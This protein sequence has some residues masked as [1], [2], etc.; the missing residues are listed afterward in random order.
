MFR[1]STKKL[2]TT[3]KLTKNFFQI[4]KEQVF[5]ADL[6]FVSETPEFQTV[7]FS[8]YKNHRKAL[9]VYSPSQRRQEII[10]PNEYKANF[11]IHEDGGILI[12]VAQN[13]LRCLGN[14]KCCFGDRTCKSCCPQIKQIYT[15]HMDLGI[16]AEDN[17]IYPT[18]Y[19]LLGDK[20]EI[21]YEKMLTALRHLLPAWKPDNFELVA[22]ALRKTFPYSMIKG[23][24]FHFN[25]C[26]WRE[27]QRLGLISSYREN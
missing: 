19:V 21:M 15:I 20:T 10:S 1:R 17:A 24:N 11:L 3:K 13:S 18:V 22:L 2:K 14:S 8:L 6:H 5:E 9:K 25:Q 26:I 12:F 23:C 7:K 4:Y 27:V 16:I